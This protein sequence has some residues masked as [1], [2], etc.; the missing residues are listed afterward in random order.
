MYGILLGRGG[1]WD[2]VR[3]GKCMGSY[4]GGEVYGILLG[5]EGVWDPIREGMCTGTDHVRQDR[6]IR[7]EPV[8]GCGVK[9]I[10][11]NVGTNLETL[12]THLIPL[13]YLS[14]PVKCS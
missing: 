7:I 10:C 5:R 3:E 12:E 4:K 13:L 8:K 11:Y 6:C 1:V 9:L 14:K 2:H